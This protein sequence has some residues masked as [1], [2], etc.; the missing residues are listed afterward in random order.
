MD[1]LVNYCSDEK[2]VKRW[3]EIF[4]GTDSATEDTLR[5]I[6]W[7]LVYRLEIHRANKRQNFLRDA[8]R[9]CGPPKSSPVRLLLQ[10]RQQPR[11]PCR[12]DAEQPPRRRYRSLSEY[13]L[14]DHFTDET[15][16]DNLEQQRQLMTLITDQYR[17]IHWAPRGRGP[18]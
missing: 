12:E 1:V 18:E 4:T 2:Y 10:W 7:E 3:Y 13:I 11:R 8:R 17:F 15:V 5:K 14:K 16:G 6:W 9:Q